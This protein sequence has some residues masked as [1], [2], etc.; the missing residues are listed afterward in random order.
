MELF[1]LGCKEQDEN[2]LA[3]YFEE[4]LRLLVATPTR[5]DIAS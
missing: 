1:E 2:K 4:I 5:R 3:A